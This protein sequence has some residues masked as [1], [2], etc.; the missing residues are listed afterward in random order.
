MGFILVKKISACKSKWLKEDQEMI[1]GDIL[2]E[3]LINELVKD[4]FA[5][6]HF[7]GIAGLLG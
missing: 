2:D 6:Y 5:I 4:K 1:V 3:K 7:A